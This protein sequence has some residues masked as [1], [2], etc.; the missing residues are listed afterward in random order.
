MSYTLVCTT[1][2]E[3]LEQREGVV[4]FRKVFQVSQVSLGACSKDKTTS[5]GTSKQK[6]PG[7]L[8]GREEKKSHSMS[9]H[10]F[11][12][13]TSHEAKASALP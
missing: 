3:M 4:Y 11:R 9:H 5:Y 12:Q 10:N 6:H 1:L 2:G 8:R 13:A 7:A